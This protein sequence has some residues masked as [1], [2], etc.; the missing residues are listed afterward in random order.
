MIDFLGSDTHHDKHIIALRQSLK[1]RQ[2]A[3]LM[4]GNLLNKKL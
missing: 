4:Q 2:L 3:S 1:S